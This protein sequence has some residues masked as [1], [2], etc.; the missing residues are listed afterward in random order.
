MEKLKVNGKV[1]PIKELDWEYLVVCD[2]EGINANRISGV[3]GLTMFVAYCSGLDREEA[4][5]EINDHVMNGGSLPELVDLY[6][7]TLSES[8]FF[9]RLLG[10]TEDSEE[11]VE[12]ETEESPKKNTKAKKVSE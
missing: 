12:E 7:K 3:A 2:M 4:G 5:K 6:K 9:R 11:T 10:Q 8:G 1:Y